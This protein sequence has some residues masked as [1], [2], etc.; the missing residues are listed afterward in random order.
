M[1]AV[2]SGQVLFGINTI[3]TVITDGQEIQCRIKG[4]VL[5]EGRRSYNPIAAGDF[6]DISTDPLNPS[7]GMIVATRPRRTV[8]ARWNKKGRARQVLAA[9]ADIA[10]CVTSTRSPPFRPRFIDRIIAAAE[11]GGMEAALLLNKTD[12]PCAEETGDRLADFSRIGYSVFSC[13]AL[14]SEGISALAESLS[15]KTVAFVGQSGVGKS[16]VLNAMDPSLGLKVGDVSHKHDRGSHTTNFSALLRLNN[17]LR[18]IDTP[19]IREL[20]LA[21]ILPEELSYRFREFTA[22][23]PS[24]RV[25]VCPHDDEPGCAVRAAVERGE[26]HYDRYESYVRI[27][28]ELRESRRSRRDYSDE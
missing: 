26:I 17:G 5:K 3:Y 10:V 20:E 12:L 4:K 22:F 21:D 7:F 9:N 11:T 19:G 1:A 23:A 8:L 2:I 15:G 18:I 16:S 6:V 27:L 14:A 13:S 28:S 24:C 25:P